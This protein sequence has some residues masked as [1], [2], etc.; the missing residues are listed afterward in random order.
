MSFD[1][2]SISPLTDCESHLERVASWHHQE[3]LRQGLTSNLHLRRSRLSLHLQNQLLPKSFIASVNDEPI[4]CVSLVNYTYKAEVD[5]NQPNC[6]EHPVWLS[7][8]YVEP[9]YRDRGVGQQL[10][11]ACADYARKHG[12]KEL[13]LSASDYTQYYLKRGWCVIRQTKLGGAKVNIMRY[14]IV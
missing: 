3:C 1:H 11:N 13:W 10:I 9:N 4:G 5:A 14:L 6:L 8:L 2:V 7:N 12:I